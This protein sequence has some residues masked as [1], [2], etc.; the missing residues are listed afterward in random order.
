MR[1]IYLWTTRIILTITMV[2]II[3]FS[4]NATTVQ[5]QSKKR[6]L[7]KQVNMLKE[8]AP[9]QRKRIIEVPFLTIKKHIS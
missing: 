6:T 2:G 3:P 5:A 4:S 7:P 8:E 1:L 9:R